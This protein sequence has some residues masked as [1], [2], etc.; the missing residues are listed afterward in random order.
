MA[1]KRL[2]N[3]VIAQ[4]LTEVV[5]DLRTDLNLHRETLEKTA[6]TKIKVDTGT[7]NET[8]S[9]YKAIFE[10]LNE[11]ASKNTEEMKNSIKQAKSSLKFNVFSYVSL[12]VC[13][14]I[15][16]FSA[17][18]YYQAEELKEENK[19]IQSTFNQFMKDSPKAKE[20]YQKWKSKK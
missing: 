12:L 10:R 13:V 5:E 16:F 11:Y 17:R 3:E 20:E 2:S 7:L 4:V 8:L 1:K 15:L 9:Q 14:L 18:W 19:K 6:G